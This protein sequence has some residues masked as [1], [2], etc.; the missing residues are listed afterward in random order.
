M[1][2]HTAAAFPVILGLLIAACGS[3]PAVPV[4]PTAPTPAAVGG[5]TVSGLVYDT[6]RRPLAGATVEAVSGPGAGVSAVANAKGEYSLTGAFDAATEFRATKEGHA[7][8]VETM[9]VPCARCNPQHWLYFF[10]A[11]PVP[12]ADIAGDYTLTVSAASSCSMLPTEMRSRTYPVNIV[13][14]PHQRTA[15]DTS[16]RATIAGGS[17]LPGLGWAD[18]WIAVAGEYLEL[19]MGDQ[20]GQPGLVDRV[21]D[22]AFLAVGGIGA[23]SVGVGRV[24]TI[25]AAFDGAIEYCVLTPGVSPI[26]GNGRYACAA[27]HSDTHAV[28]HSPDHQLILKRNDGTKQ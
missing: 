9:P 14:L 21:Y 10:L 4:M 26:D 5:V 7:D 6:A 16:F 1:R 3:S 22:N 24:S 17:V 25:T 8:A 23:T 2:R 11:L 20:H 19:S 12:P 27:P 13:A 15:A 18:L 28:C